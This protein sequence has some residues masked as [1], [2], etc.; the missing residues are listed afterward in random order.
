MYCAF[1]IPYAEAEQLP[2]EVLDTHYFQPVEVALK[3]TIGNME[4]WCGLHLKGYL[5]VIYGGNDAE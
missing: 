2:F 3:N 1:V 5:V 4:I